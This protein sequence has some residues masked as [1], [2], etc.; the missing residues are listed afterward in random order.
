VTDRLVAF[1]NQLVE[2][3][4]HLRETL[5]RLRDGAVPARD[6]RTHCLT[7]CA[8]LTRHHEAED[9]G[10]FPVLA[11]EHPELAP[12]LDELARD[13]VLIANT[14]RRLT[15]LLDSNGDGDGD[16]HTELASLAALLEA[17]LVYEEKKI[18]AA[19]NGL[20]PDAADATFLARA[21]TIPG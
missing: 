10:A 19:L 21:T 14:M 2:T 8:V 9:T 15:E 5:D 17:H 3:H 13:H 4:L 6:L 16:V 12:V 18:V 7:F 11:R 20:H 1:G